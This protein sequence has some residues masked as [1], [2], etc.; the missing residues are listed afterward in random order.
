MSS[1]FEQRQK[2]QFIG[3]LTGCIILLAAII[4][5]IS[6]SANHKVLNC[7][8]ES[9]IDEQTTEEKAVHFVWNFGRLTEA[10]IQDDYKTVDEITKEQILEF[11]QSFEDTGLYENITYS[12]FFIYQVRAEADFKKDK[13]TKNFGGDDYETV[14]SV[15]ENTYLMTC[16]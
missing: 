10:K 8:S 1:S 9:T 2:L 14:K 15:F 16:E 7:T 4:L 13:I 12:D 5:V 3:Y 6:Y 11:T